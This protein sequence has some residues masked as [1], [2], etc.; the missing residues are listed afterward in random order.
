MARRTNPKDEAE[1]ATNVDELSKLSD[2]ELA[3]L[4][5]E[6][7]AKRTE[8]RLE[9]IAVSAEIDLRRALGAM[10]AESRRIIHI[11]LEGGISPSGDA[12]PEKE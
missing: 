11:R 1:G 5:A 9:Q 12:T 6:L 4:D 2:D 3:A 10:S 8:I 7:A